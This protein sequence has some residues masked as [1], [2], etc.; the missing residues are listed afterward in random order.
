MNYEK[1]LK[2]GKKERYTLGLANWLNGEAI[3]SA[4]ATPCGAGFTVESTDFS[5][6]TVGFFATGATA[7]R[8]DVIIAYAT[9][10]RSDSQKHQIAVV[11]ADACG[12]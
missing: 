10:T 2:V 3:T 11:A 4:T 1:P 8:F 5:G 12:V 6:S 7:G 9:A